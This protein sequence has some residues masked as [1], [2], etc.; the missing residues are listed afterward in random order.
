MKKIVCCQRVKDI[1]Q[2]SPVGLE[3]E[4]FPPEALARCGLGILIVK[5]AEQMQVQLNNFGLEGIR[6][7]LLSQGGIHCAG[8]CH[9]QI[10]LFDHVELPR[11]NVA[12][13]TELGTD[14]ALEST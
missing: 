10:P 7:I 6:S 3:E 12:S 2:S 13:S 9:R 14:R 5:Q 4:K 1:I 11:P 8:S